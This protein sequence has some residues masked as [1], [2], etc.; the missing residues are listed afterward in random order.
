[1]SLKPGSVL[2]KDMDP[3]TWATWCRQDSTFILVTA[4]NIA[5]K[6]STINLDGKYPGR[7]VY[8]T[9][10]HRLMIARGSTNT[11]VWDV[12]DGSASVTPS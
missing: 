10:N 4:A 2:P 8:D 6:D 11:A 3:R 5:D 7:A 9:N 1:M 12:V